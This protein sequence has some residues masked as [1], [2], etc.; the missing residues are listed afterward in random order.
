MMMA[1]GVHAHPAP[2]G[3]IKLVNRYIKGSNRGPPEKRE[4]LG[5]VN[6]PRALC[7]AKG[8]GGAKK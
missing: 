2:K 3:C 7:G 4:D 5:E 8:S 1:N 6:F